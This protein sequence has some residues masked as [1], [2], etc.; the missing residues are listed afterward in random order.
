MF[1][2][3]IQNYKDIFRPAAFMNSACHH[4]KLR[5][6]PLD[7]LFIK[8]ETGEAITQL[9]TRLTTFFRPFRLHIT[10]N[11]IRGVMETRRKRLLE[12]GKIT[13]T[14]SRAIQRVIGHS[15][16][17]AERHYILHDTENAVRHV[18]EADACL[19]NII[20]ESG[21]P[22]TTPNQYR[23]RDWGTAHPCYGKTIAEFTAEETEYVKC[24][25]EE[26]KTQDRSYGLKSRLADFCKKVIHQ[27]PNAT[28]IFHVNHVMR[29][30]S[31][32]PLLRKLKLVK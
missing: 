15:D 20:P 21:F 28:E 2:M 29:A 32:R 18:R 22:Q 11:T 5:T 9:G 30:S 12:E 14:Q 25:V 24:I 10:T 6:S 8:W 16:E 4:N 7:P 26:Y 23:H 27:D 31:L 17:T 1:R 3:L 13:D 19:N